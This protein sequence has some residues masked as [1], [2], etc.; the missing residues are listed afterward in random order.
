MSSGWFIA[1]EGVDGCGKST[2]AA[3]LADDRGALLTRQPGG[4]PIGA[5]LRAVLLD[6]RYGEMHERAEAMLMAADRAQ[7]VAELVR[8]ALTSGRDVVCDRYIGSSLAYQGYGRGLPLEEVRHLSE[9]ATAGLWP[10][11]IVLLDVPE[12]VSRDRM[13][14][15][16]D[17]LEQVGADFDRRV[18]RGFYELA[19]A[20]PE[21]WAVVDGM[22]TVDEVAVRVNGI[23]RDRL[24]S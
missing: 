1:F 15:E 22:G 2:Q 6:P 23:V 11:V 16:R 18:R 13:P 21:R 19:R 24:G 8:P 20:E 12:S 9:W 10:D 7:H 3:R 14:A 5:S 4:T 17:R